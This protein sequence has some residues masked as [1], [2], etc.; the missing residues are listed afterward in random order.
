MGIEFDSA[1][2][3]RNRAQHQL[4]LAL[5]RY[6]LATRI[7]ELEDIR[8][9]YGET[10]IVAFGYLGPRLHCVVYTLRGAAIRVISLRKANR[11]EI[12]RWHPA[13]P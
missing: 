4:S 7:G 12:Q 1:K 8:R 2:E 5:A 11:K 3:A 6:V 13:E 9:D 10:R